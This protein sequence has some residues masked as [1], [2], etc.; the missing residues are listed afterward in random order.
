MA[1]EMPERALSATSLEV[2]TD[3]DSLINVEKRRRKRFLCNPNVSV[4]S[5][6]KW[7]AK[8]S[9]V[10]EDTN[11]SSTTNVHSP[12]LNISTELDEQSYCSAVIETGSGIETEA[13]YTETEHSFSLLYD[14]DNESINFSDNEDHSISS[15]E[16]DSYY[17]SS[18][19]DDDLLT[20]S[21]DQESEHEME[22]RSR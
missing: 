13:E 17:L 14:N 6:R 21:D 9:K 2:E 7:R 1:S 3:D 20:V 5:R 12:H 22:K 8:K 18:D 11:E 16:T 10:T 15:S 19:D 4:L